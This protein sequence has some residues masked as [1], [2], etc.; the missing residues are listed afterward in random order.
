MTKPQSIVFAHSNGFTGKTYQYFLEQF[1][2]QNLTYIEK[3]GTGKYT[4]FTKWEELVPQ[5]IEHIEHHHQEPIIGIG[6]S[7]GAAVLFFTAQQRPDLFS[8][9]LIIEPPIFSIWKRIIY[10]FFTVIG[11][12][13]KYSPAGKSAK[14]RAIFP[15]RTVAYEALRNKGI[16]KRFDEKCFQDYIKYGFVDTENSVELDF[17]KELETKFFQ[18]PPF[19]VSKKKFEMPVHFLYSKYFKTLTKQDIKWWKRNFSYFNFHEI[20]GGHMFP[21][22]KPE[23]TAS[24]LKSLF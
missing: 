19:S 17:S 2:S 1:E 8:K 15:S 22:E 7:L 16:F 11:Q 3:F 24:F 5:L 10:K 13:D 18:R 21:L 4:N 20:D 23:E 14:R 12:A 9:I 6:H